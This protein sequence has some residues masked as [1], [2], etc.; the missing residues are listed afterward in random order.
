MDFIQDK[1]SAMK[2]KYGFAFLSLCIIFLSSFANAQDWPK[3]LSTGLR[4]Q[5]EIVSAAS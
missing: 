2:Q 1:I 3:E 4:R 5:G